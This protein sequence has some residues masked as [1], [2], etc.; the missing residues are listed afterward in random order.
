MARIEMI[1]DSVRRGLYRSAWA[2]IL[3]ERS[4]GRYLPV[5][6]AR[7][8]VDVIKAKLFTGESGVPSTCDLSIPGIDVTS[9]KLESVTINAFVNNIFHAELSLSCCHGQRMID[10]LAGKALA[11]SVMAGTPIFAEEAVLDKAGLEMSQMRQI[12]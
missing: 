3:K 12:G 11:L 5:Y 6:I 10:C 4:G 7:P 9:G 1:I 2:I 8:Y